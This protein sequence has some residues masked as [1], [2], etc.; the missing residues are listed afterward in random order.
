MSWRFRHSFKIIPGVHL[1]LSRSGL[2]ASIGG[3][4]FTLNV[5]PRG[6]V[7]TASLPGTGISYR[8]QFG[9]APNGF[10]HSS[11]TPPTPE[12]ASTSPPLM[13]TPSS[14]P[15]ILPGHV[16]PPMH[17][18]RSAATELL[19][20]QSL[21]A[22]KELIQTTHRERDDILRELGAAG[23]KSFK[24]GG[25]YSSWDSGFLL[26]RVFKK[27]FLKR[28]AENDSAKAEV[29]ELKEQLRL[30]TIVAQLEVSKE[31]AEPYFHMRDE[32]AA[33]CECT[34]IWDKKAWRQVSKLR[35]RTIANEMI[36]RESVTFELGTCDLITWDQKVPH[37]QNA[38]GG[39]LFFYPGF[40]LYRASRQTFSVIDFHEVTLTAEPMNFVE[41][42]T[43]PSDS[44]VVG[45]TWAK[46]NKDGSRDRRF[47]NNYMV[48]VVRYADLS[49]KS[50]SGLWEEFQFSDPSRAERFAKAWNGFVTS[51]DAQQE[52]A[53]DEPQLQ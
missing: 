36:D 25:R 44:R 43:V 12:A 15:F 41:K 11:S 17:E 8:H 38:N 48:P 21:Q 47:V 35:D 3:A 4:P 29:E 7:G 10:P 9:G 19:T 40:I 49:F 24:A 2:S 31:Q 37:L 33:L 45:Q 26:K 51:F 1:N 27:S 50:A 20:S 13:P 16:L 28:K 30:T 6:V 53:P 18:I 32:F 14:V 42:E 22:L 23:V 52:S 39:D 5:G 46:A 34:A